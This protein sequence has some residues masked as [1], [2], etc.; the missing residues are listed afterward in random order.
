MSK[1]A[2]LFTRSLAIATFIGGMALSPHLYAQT[3][4]DTSPP[5]DAP[6]MTAPSPQV[7]GSM[8]GHSMKAEDRVEKRIQELHDKLKIT[9]DQASAWQNV[10]DTMRDNEKNVHTLIMERHSKAG[11]L[12]AIDDL[13]SYQ[14]I[15]AAHAD[16]MSKFIQAFQ[17]LY[18]SMSATQKKQ[19]DMLFASYEGHGDHGKH[20]QKKSSSKN[21]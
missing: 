12:S 16:G 9:D 5:P 13:N 6:A 4:S 10:A 20:M 1:S 21:Q 2:T 19:A 7:G 18:D 8:K 17:P 14:Q 11:T 3:P 15:A